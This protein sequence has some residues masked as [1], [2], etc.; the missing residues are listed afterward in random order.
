MFVSQEVYT[1]DDFSLD[2]M[3]SLSGSCG[4]RKSLS[5]SPPSEV[6]SSM[7]V[8]PVATLFFLLSLIVAAC[9]GDS[10]GS[11][12]TTPATTQTRTIRL[13]G[14]LEFGDVMLG[15]SADR[16]LRIYNEGNSPMTVTSLTGPGGDVFTATWTGGTI[17]PGTSQAATIRFRPIEART[18]TGMVTVNA[19]HTSGTNTTPIS[20][21]GVAPTPATAPPAGPAISGTVR[22]EGTTI[23]IPGATVVVKDTTFASNSDGAGRC[24][25][26]GV[27]NGNYMLRATA[28]GY[29]LAER[30]VSV[31]GAVTADIFMRKVSAPTPSPTPTPT[32]TPTPPG[33]CCRVCTVGKACGDTCINKD[34]TCKTPLGCAC[35]GI[36]GVALDYTPVPVPLRLDGR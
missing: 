21:K 3:H 8:K 36:T 23:T 34:F 16:T 9:G 33:N 35:N 29:Q 5:K 22:E 27:P 24:S 7:R 28:G 20:A 14:I 17:A 26:A 10:G 11:S 30:T 2:R 13:E 15:D 19:N 25:I 12:P 31:N 6:R 32:P 18:Y 4:P 1:R